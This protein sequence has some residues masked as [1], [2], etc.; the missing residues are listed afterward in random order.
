MAAQRKGYKGMPMEGIVACWYTRNTGRDLR[1]FREAARAVA[2]RAKPAARVLEV[3]PGPGYLAIELAKA[4]YPV[5]GLDISR[6]FVRIAGENAARAG[7]SIDVRHGDAAHMPFLDASFDFVVCMAAFKNFADPMGALDEMHRVLAPG[8]QASILDLR[9]DASREA[10]DEEVRGMNLS[11]VNAA[12]TR[13]IFG[14]V[15]LKN[16]YA[17]ADLE[18]MMVRSRFGGGRIADDG[19]GF[20]LQ[21]ERPA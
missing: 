6:S 15:L 19:V 20:E 1:R 13:W 16:A 7:V 21:L 3:A 2:A 9:R 17:R 12:V 11:A 18:R 5:T 10:I 4:G 14:H 8:G